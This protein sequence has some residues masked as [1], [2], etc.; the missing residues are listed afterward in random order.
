M[1]RRLRLLTETKQIP[2]EHNRPRLLV[3]NEIAARGVLTTTYLPILDRYIQCF[4]PCGEPRAH[5]DKSNICTSGQGLTRKGIAHGDSDV[6]ADLK[7][8]AW[9]QSTARL[10]TT[11]YQQVLVNLCYVLSRLA[12]G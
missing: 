11:P 2:D 12:L 8:P 7:L 10:M 4:V 3:T 6:V 5:E 9:S 1:T